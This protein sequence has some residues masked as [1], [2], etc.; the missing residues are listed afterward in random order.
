MSQMSCAT[1]PP[2]IKGLNKAAR[3]VEPNG[4][5]ENRGDSHRSTTLVL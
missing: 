3:F 2:Q 4:V 5:D 1:A